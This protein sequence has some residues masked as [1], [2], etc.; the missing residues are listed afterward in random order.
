MAVM[1]AITAAAIAFAV[2]RLLGAAAGY[3]RAQMEHAGEL[4]KAWEQGAQAVDDTFRA[5]GADRRAALAHLT[6]QRR[7]A[8]RGLQ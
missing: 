2:G 4:L 7:N 1:V 8:Q 3:H 6:A 5:I